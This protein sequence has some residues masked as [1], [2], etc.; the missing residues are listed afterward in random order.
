[1]KT[2]EYNNLRESSWRRPLTP[3]EQA[4]V[5][6]YLAENPD[7][8]ADWEVDAQLNRALERLPDAAAVSS[9]FTARVL[10]TVRLEAAAAERERSRGGF[11]W[12]NFRRFIPRL[13]AVALAMGLGVAGWRLH[14][15]KAR[16]EQARNLAGLASVISANPE[17]MANYE[18]IRRL[19]G[20]EVTPDIELIALLQ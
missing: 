18:P 13:A 8:R 1:M 19:G 11:A 5:E 9:N 17:V 20:N 10:E 12:R 6:Q 4:A 14:E 7:A 3:T 15:V 2:P 16:A